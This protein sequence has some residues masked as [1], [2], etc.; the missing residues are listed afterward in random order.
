[1]SGLENIETATIPRNHWS[2]IS[3]AGLG[4]AF[5]MP[6][7]T[8]SFDNASALSISNQS[9]GGSISSTITTINPTTLPQAQQASIRPGDH[10]FQIEV[11]AG[12]QRITQFDGTLSVTV[13]FN[14]TPPINAWRL[15]ANGMLE[16]LTA[17]FNTNSNT[18]TFQTNRLSIFVVGD[19]THT[20]QAAP[21]LLGLSTPILSLTIGNTAFTHM[22]I[23]KQND[24]APFID[25]A[26]NRTMVP[27][28]VI[29]EGLGANVRFEETT[30]TVYIARAGVEISLV[31]NTPL[32][33]GM[34]T[35]VIINNRT[36]VPARYV[37]EFLSAGLSW[38]EATGVVNIY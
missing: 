21:G 17:V 27:L 29:A 6:S 25:S 4:I 10:V 28:R 24:V 36:F 35:P 18:V 33:G 2:R 19:Y 11:N 15:N 30:N 22:G 8:L 37:S 3:D 14:G 20:S 7:G 16:E 23:T 13:D 38:D 34:G 32:P 5:E 26:T 12:N 31:I 1:M 9:R